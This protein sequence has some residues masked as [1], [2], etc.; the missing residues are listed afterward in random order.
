MA[1][2]NYDAGTVRAAHSNGFEP[3]DCFTDGELHTWLGSKNRGVLLMGLDPWLLW[4]RALVRI[5]R[6]IAVC[7][8]CLDH[9][10]QSIVGDRC[11]SRMY[12]DR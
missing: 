1:R 4:I 6:W 7:G 5:T 11:Q 8:Q 9:G 10:R 12:V 2:G 3:D